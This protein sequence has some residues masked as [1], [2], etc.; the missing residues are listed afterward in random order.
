M[1]NMPSRHPLRWSWWLLVPCLVTAFSSPVSAAQAD[2]SEAD[3]EVALAEKKAAQAFEAY[4]AKRFAEAVGL[5]L[6]AHRAAPNADILY[7]VARI[8]DA[9]LGDRPLAI[10]FYRRYIADPGAVADRIQVANERLITLRE[11]EL[12]V[13][14]AAPATDAPPATP[15]D[16]SG[17]AASALEPGWS[18]P[19]VIGAVMGIT[20]VVAI[21]VGAG[22]GIAAMRETQTMHDL[23]EGNV[24]SE[25]RGIDAAESASDHATISTI[26][27]VS[28][29]A[30]LAFGA[31]F[32][33][34]LGSE[35]SESPKQASD[36]GLRL[37][38]HMGRNP[39][40]FGLELGGSW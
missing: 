11:A 17:S 26:G 3:A 28:G 10:S 25:Q 8:Y 40:A 2:G 35:P 7:N 5:Y 39:G 34:W 6:E 37:G 13:A 27:F 32:H 15:S 18:T 31:A 21:G 22:F 12:A 20:G 16:G 9:K 23:C 4:Q 36:A 14:R 1:L 24:C 19:E 38:A 30:L 33:Y 29:G